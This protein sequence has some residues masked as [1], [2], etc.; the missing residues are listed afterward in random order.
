LTDLSEAKLRAAALTLFRAKH[1][2]AVVFRHEDSLRA[3]IPDTSISW[4]GITSWWEFKYA[5]PT[6]KWRGA[7]T[8]EM[9][10][11][12]STGIP[13]HFVIYSEFRG[14]GPELRIVPATDSYKNLQTPHYAVNFNHRILLDC[15]ERIHRRV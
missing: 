11:M 13:A 3:G 12:W 14:S 5:N 1:P 15:I 10:R 8:A 6:I 2:Q 4:R 9:R 7:Q